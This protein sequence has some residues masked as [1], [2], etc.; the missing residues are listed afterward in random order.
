MAFE[1]DDPEYDDEHDDL[2]ALDFSPPYDE[3]QDSGL[4]ALEDYVAGSPDDQ[5]ADA[6]NVPLFAVT[7][8]PGTVT[9]TTHMDGRV[10]QINLSPKAAAMTERDLAEEIVLIADLAAQ[11]ARSAQYAFMF[12]GMQAHGHD[13][14]ATRDF[15][16][17]DLGL[18]TP[19]QAQAAR[20]ELFATR[21][22]GG[23]V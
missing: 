9:V 1:P 22:A 11:D 18:P 5:A 23:H 20:T 4:D 15:L 6:D 19:E 16:T 17:R 2:V 10:Q 12:A 7:N 14:A 21:Y 3:Y 13:P 8:P